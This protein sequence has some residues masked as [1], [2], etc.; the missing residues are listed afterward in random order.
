MKARMQLAIT[1][2]CM[3]YDNNDNTGDPGCFFAASVTKVRLQNKSGWI[4][5]S[6][7]AVKRHL[8]TVLIVAWEFTT[9]ALI[10]KTCP[11]SV[12]TVRY[13]S[14]PCLFLFNY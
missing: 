9:A 3:S 6:A 13:T 11:F 14:R 8:T 12:A 2:V 10:L 1:Y 7:V 5:C 4:T